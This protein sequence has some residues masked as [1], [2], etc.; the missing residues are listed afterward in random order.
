[1]TSRLDAYRSN[2]TRLVAGVM[3]GTSLDAIDVAF[4]EISGTGASL[5]HRLV[6]FHSREFDEAMRERLLAACAGDL[7]MREAFELDAD[8]GALYA[9][10]I[11]EG[12][13]GSDIDLESIA[14]VGL[15]GQTIYHAPDR[16]PNG[17][18]VQIGSAAMVASRLGAIVV[19]SFREADVAAGG[20]GAPL[21]P[22]CDYLLLRKAGVN[23]VALNIGGIA[24]LSWLPA[25]VTPD[26]LVAFDTGPGNMLIDA[27]MRKLRGLDCDRDGAVAAAGT[28]DEEWV[29][30][31][32]SDPYYHQAPP[33]SAG[34][35]A[36]GEER[37][38]ALVE[39][40][41]SR[42][43]TEEGIIASLTL[44]TA[45]SIGRGIE[46]HA[47]KGRAIDEMVIGGGGTR[48]P[49][50]MR[51]LA[52]EL[53]ATAMIDGADAGLP[54]DAKEA[55]CFAILANEAIC[56]TPANIPSVTGASRRVVCGAGWMA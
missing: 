50:L 10:V 19:D 17:V 43:L 26:T 12:A 51:M 31:L 23:R 11:C 32:L 35:E 25:D 27:A 45:R 28:A 34:R 22:Y 15:H 41:R 54:A 4:V 46:E 36:F 14:A 1:M 49:T 2:P 3:S 44:L 5:R 18:T 29:E 33:K 48:N 53:P 7:R 37:G 9:D 20:E 47:A 40:G 56:E 42:G 30:S 8:L 21:V 55:I 16:K 52:A 39:E 38:V 13:D 6:A 24:N